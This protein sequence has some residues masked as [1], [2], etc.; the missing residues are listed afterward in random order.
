MHGSTIASAHSMYRVGAQL[1]ASK[2]RS[3]AKETCRGFLELILTRLLSPEKPTKMQVAR[4]PCGTLKSLFK[5]RKK[6]SAIERKLIAETRF[7]L[8]VSCRKMSGWVR[9]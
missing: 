4:S 1:Y 5:I 9:N 8:I 2:V 7:G 3:D 6:P